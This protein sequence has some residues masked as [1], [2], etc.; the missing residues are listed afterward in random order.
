VKKFINANKSPEIR[1]K[2]MRSFELSCI[3]IVEDAFGNYAVQ[4]AIDSYGSQVCWNLLDI[5]IRNI[6]SL[7]NQ[8][9]SSNVV[10]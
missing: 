8:K 7:S 10:D 5:V 1:E 3:E 9:F 4:Y 6:L 2:L